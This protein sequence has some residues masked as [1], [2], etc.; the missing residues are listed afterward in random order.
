MDTSKSAYL[1]IRESVGV[2]WNVREPRSPTNE[3][4]TS[5]ALAGG[6]L[7]KLFKRTTGYVGEVGIL[8]ATP[9]KNRHSRGQADR[10][11]AITETLRS[12]TAGVPC[13]LQLMRSKVDSES[14]PE[15]RSPQGVAL[16]HCG[17]RAD[18][19][20]FQRLPGAADRPPR[21]PSSTVA[22][23]ARCPAGRTLPPHSAP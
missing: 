17:N 18:V 12:R 5:V 14:N 11:S 16:Q 23:R 10:V 7:R 9:Q 4:K 21:D 8:S 1:R 15:C 22:N 6:I 13:E 20:T 19:N 3:E 2:P